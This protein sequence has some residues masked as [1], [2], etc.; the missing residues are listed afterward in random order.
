MSGLVK[1][2]VE[3]ADSLTTGFGSN[4]QKNLIGPEY[5]F[6]FGMNDA[7]PGAKMLIVKTAWGGKTLAADFRPPSSVAN[8]AEDPFCTAAYCTEVGH[9]YSVMIADVHAMLAPGAIAQMFPDLAGLTP[10][11]A[12]FGWFQGWNDG[13]DSMY[14]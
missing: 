13:C 5:G 14:P 3:D 12:G 2:M 10:V 1:M 11:V 4:C 7:N 6:G 8:V 9:Y